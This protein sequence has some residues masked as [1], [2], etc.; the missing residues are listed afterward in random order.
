MLKFFS[1]GSDPLPSPPLSI[2][3]DPPLDVTIT[4]P[5]CP[6]ILRDSSRMSGAAFAAAETHKILTNGPKLG[7]T[8]IPLAVETFCDWGKEARLTFSGLASH[9]SISMSSPKR[10]ILV[11]IYGRLNMT[12]QGRIQEFFKGGGTVKK[13][14][15]KWAWIPRRGWVR[16]GD[17]P[18]PARSAEA[19]DTI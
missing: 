2:F 6:T 9:L 18:P 8:Y 17:M 16:E 3:L 1:G 11:D 19:F 13:S 14:Y 15:K 7:W 10:S 4:L 12:L 5:L